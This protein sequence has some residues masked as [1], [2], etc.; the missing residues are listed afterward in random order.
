[1]QQGWMQRRNRSVAWVI[2]IPGLFSL[3]TGLMA[4]FNTATGAT[5]VS[6]IVGIQLLLA[7]IA[8]VVLAFVKRKVVNIVKDKAAE[9]R[10][11]V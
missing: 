4:I 2:F 5:A 6:I 7:G 8:L 11:A 10:N 1:M 3:I 9:L